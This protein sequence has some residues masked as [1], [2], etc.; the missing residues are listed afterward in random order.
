MSD[1]DLIDQLGEM[2]LIKQ[3]DEAR[4]ERDILEEGR[5]LLNRQ[6]EQMR[7]ERDEARAEIERLE[8]VLARREAEAQAEIDMLRKALEISVRWH[9]LQNGGDDSPPDWLVKNGIDT[10]IYKA[11]LTSA[12][13]RLAHEEGNGEGL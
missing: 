12:D 11:R 4:R 8:G 3:R 6:V 5:A 10:C 2:S 1:Y 7:R 9:I 13:T